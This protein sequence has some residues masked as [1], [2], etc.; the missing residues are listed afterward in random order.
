VNLVPVICATFVVPILTMRLLSEEKRTGTLEVLLTAPVSE[1]TVVLSKFFASLVFFLIAWAPWAL[2]LVALRVMGGEEFD[3]RPVLSFFVALA[4]TGAGFLSMGLFFSSL[5]RNQIA[6]AVLTF[7]G[8]LGWLGVFLINR[9]VPEV[10]P[11]G[12]VNPWKAVLTHFSYV[13]LWFSAAL[14]TLAPRYLFFHLSLTI[15]W[16]FLTVKVIEARKWS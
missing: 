14:G 10:L 8:M 5:T 15:F 3:T 4:F 11:N 16:L 2:C 9:A 12:A 13:D 6:A 1:T 7:M